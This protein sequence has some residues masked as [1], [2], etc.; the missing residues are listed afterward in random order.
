MPLLAAL[1]YGLRVIATAR[2][3]ETLAPLKEKGAAALALDVTSPVEDLKKFATEAI[4]VYGQVDYLVN[5]AGYLQ[6]GAIEEN[7]PEE[8][9]N[10]FNTNF[11]GLVNTTNAFLPHFR[12]R[13]TG[14][15]VNISSQ[16]AVLGVTGGG[17]YCASKA[18]VDTISHTW[19]N[20]LREY[21]IRC[22]SVQPGAFRTAVAESS[23]LRV[24]KAHIDGYKAAHEWVAGFSANA[25]KERG[26][27]AKAAVK[28]I[29]FIATDPQ[30]QL[31]SRF[32]I[33]DDAYENVK[34]FHTQRLKEVEEWKELST[35]T[36]A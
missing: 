3:P 28:I 13:R 10:Q 18:A 7:T 2:R 36:D 27:T 14:T 9:L 15:I 1:N 4:N 29:D 12:A 20:E 26:D 11:F 25:G 33:G 17:I 8:N 6:G 5:N 23:N 22:V 34:N 30:R 31:P 19:A 21:G 32:A 24:A 16:G 35:G